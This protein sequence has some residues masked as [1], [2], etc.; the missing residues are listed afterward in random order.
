MRSLPFSVWT[1]G[2]FASIALVVGLQYIVSR[3]NMLAFF[4][5]RDIF[6]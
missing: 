3:L 2:Y 1:S 4:G 5:C 6:D